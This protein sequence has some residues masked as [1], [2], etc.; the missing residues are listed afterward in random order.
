MGQIYAVCGPSGAGK[1]SI[2]KKFFESRPAN[3]RL[4]SR[5]TAR[6]IRLDECNKTEFEFTNLQGFIHLAFANDLVDFIAYNG[7]PYGI[8]GRPI[9]ETIRS[10]KDAMI[11]T[12]SS[13]AVTLKTK[14]PNSVTLLYIYPGTR[15]D[16]MNISSLDPGSEVNLELKWR[17]KKKIEKGVLKPKSGDKEYIERRMQRSFLGISFINGQLR[18]GL[19]LKVIQNERDKLSKA[20]DKLREVI[21][22][23]TSFIKTSNMSADTCFVLMPFKEPF[24]A[25]Y[26]DHIK[27]VVDSIGLA[28]LRGDKIFSNRPIMDDIHQAVRKAKI[29][30][31]DLTGGNPN[32]YYETGL[33]HAINKEVILITQDDRAPIDL[34]HFRRIKY[35]YTAP[36]M[37]KFEYELKETLKEVC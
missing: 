27:P 37:K 18:A 35:T 5:I 2:I 22:V 12:G 24:D 25:V 36:G 28:C 34:Q 29:I 3:I 21:E 16:L 4:L 7:Y 19:D 13:G 30:I 11:M 14:Y 20:V 15:E 10:N 32:V 33:C 31:S 17:I 23:G 9:V 8:R 6:P 26:S 1:S